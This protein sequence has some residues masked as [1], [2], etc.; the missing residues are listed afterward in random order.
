MWLVKQHQ[1][2][3]FVVVQSVVIARPTKVKTTA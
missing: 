1:Q 2:A 3:I